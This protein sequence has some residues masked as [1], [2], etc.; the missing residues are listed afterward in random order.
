MALRLWNNLSAGPKDIIL[1]FK[2]GF[3]LYE[4]MEYEVNKPNV[5]F[6]LLSFEEQKSAFT[7]NGDHQSAFTNNVMFSLGCRLELCA[8]CLGTNLIDPPLPEGYDVCTNWM[9]R[10]VH[11]DERVAIS[12]FA[13]FLSILKREIQEH[14][15]KEMGFAVPTKLDWWT[16]TF[17]N[18]AYYDTVDALKDLAGTAEG[19]VLKKVLKSFKFE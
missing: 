7:D 1:E 8:N 4:I 17:P 13:W 5:G 18:G 16:R 6:E 15:C 14:T 10:V 12:A 9:T 11:V 2:A 3:E 19:K